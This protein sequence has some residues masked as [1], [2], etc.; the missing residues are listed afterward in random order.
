MDFSVFP[1]SVHEPVRAALLAVLSE[2][3]DK[4]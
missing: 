3:D 4:V 1:E 2:P